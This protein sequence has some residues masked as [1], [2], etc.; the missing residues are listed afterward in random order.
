MS[1]VT[2]TPSPLDRSPFQASAAG[3]MPVWLT[4]WPALPLGTACPARS[5]K[6]L[7]KLLFAS[8]SAQAA[9]S[10]FS[11]TVPDGR[12]RYDP[13]KLLAKRIGEVA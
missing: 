3:S 2:I 9:D 10:Y 6:V 12:S 4:S 7:Q 13:C 5:P 1:A 11:D 8:A